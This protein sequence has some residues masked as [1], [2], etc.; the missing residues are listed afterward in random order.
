MT[1]DICG[2]ST[3][4][5]EPC[6]NPAG[7]NGFCWIPSHNPGQDDENPHG[8]PTKLTRDRQ[9]NI[10]GMIEKGHSINAACRSNGIHRETFYD[11]M[12]RG[13]EQEEGIYADFSDRLTRALGEGERMYE[14]LLLEIARQNEDAATV[15]TMLKQRFPESWGD[16]DR[17]DQSAGVEVYLEAEETIEVE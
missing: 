6:Q 8:R 13:D 17:G 16:V 9:E 14:N 11:W 3:T 2:V 5:D 15:M 4:Q 10:A 12:R 1:D 7:D